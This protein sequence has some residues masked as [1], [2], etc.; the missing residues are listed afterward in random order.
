MYQLQHLISKL[1][2]R[3]ILRSD[4]A[5]HLASQTTFEAAQESRS[6]QCLVSGGGGAKADLLKKMIAEEGLE[7]RV[8]MVGPVPHE[9]ARDLLVSLLVMI[10]VWCVLVAIWCADI[11]S[12]PCCLSL[13]AAA[14]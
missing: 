1:P 13:S 7:S 6:S 5:L 9:K 12:L 11:V 14:I 4:V 3:L 10:P 8:E 2:N